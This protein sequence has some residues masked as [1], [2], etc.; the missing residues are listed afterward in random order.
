MGKVSITDINVLRKSTGAGLMDCKKALIEADG[1][2]DKA[3]EILR[4]KGQKVVAK[5][6]DRESSEGIVLTKINKDNTRGV[7]FSLNCETDFVAKTE[8]FQKLAN[9]LVDLALE[10][11]N[12]TD[13]LKATFGNS[14]VSDSLVELSGVIGEKLE[15]GTLQILEAPFVG[16]Y[17]HNGNRVASLVGLSTNVPE[18]KDVAENLAMQ[19]VAMKPIAVDENDVAPEVIAKEEEIAKDVLRKEGKPEHLLNNIVKGK[20]K[21]FFS[22][23]TLIHQKYISDDKKSVSKFISSVNPILKVTGFKLYNLS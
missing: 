2:Q 7:L 15:I 4:K 5:R 22:E 21:K 19:V 10:C 11:D 3:V 17:I 6:S 23:N 16:S 8:K 9:Q 14:N 13:F 20:L 12:K 1:N 18:S